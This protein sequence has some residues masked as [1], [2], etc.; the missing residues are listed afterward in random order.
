MFAFTLEPDR[1]LLTATLTGEWSFETVLAYEPHLRQQ[2]AL[3]RASGRPRLFIVDCRTVVQND[4]VGEALRLAVARLGQLHPDRTA[5]VFAGSIEKNSARRVGDL[6]APIFPTM[7]LAR[8]WVTG[9]VYR[10]QSPATVHDEPSDAISEGFAV[11]I[12]GPA[13]VDLVLTP[14]AALETA[15]RISDAAVGAL[16]EKARTEPG[17]S[18]VPHF[19]EAL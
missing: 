11:R 8:D 19:V 10:A 5:V 15:R 2:L 16:M 13:D 17:A 18:G 3:L 7:E 1:V 4:D 12:H 14:A 9:K 6:N